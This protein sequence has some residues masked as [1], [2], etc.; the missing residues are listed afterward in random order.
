MANHIHQYQFECGRPDD[1][2]TLRGETLELCKDAVASP[3]KGFDS[4]AQGCYLG[5]SRA[6]VPE[7]NLLI[8]TGW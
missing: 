3:L 8:A 7:A 5:W 2:T 4:L 6:K 1:K